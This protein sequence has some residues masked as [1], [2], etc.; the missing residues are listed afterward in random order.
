MTVNQGT[1]A[2]A[3]PDQDKKL[4][5]IIAEQEAIFV[6]RQP[7]SARLARTAQG[8]LAGG[9]T[10]SWQ[11]TAPQPVWLSH[12]QGSKVYDVDGQAY[13]DLHGG[14]GA[15]LAG[16]AHPA[17][18]RAVQEQVARGTHFAQ[19]T[20]N[21]I[22]VAEEL[23]RRFGLPQWR[24]G[25]SGTEA[26]MDAV[27]LM[28]SITGRDL[29]IKVEGGYHGHH[30]SVQ[31][32]VMPEPEDMG[33]AQRPASAAASSGIPDAIVQLT[34]VTAFND[35]AGVD[36]VL[37][38]H[39]GQVAG[40]IVE[41]IMMNAGIIQ[42][43]PG[44]LAALKDLLHAHGALLTFDEVKTGLTSGPA[45][46][47]GLSGVTPDIICLAKALGGGVAVAAVGGSAEVMDH[48]ASG[49][50]EIVGTFNGNPLAM[51][52]ARAMLT[53]VATPAAYDHIDRLR[54]RAVTGIEAAIADHGLAA[55]VVAVGAKGCVVFSPE[56][57]HDYRG[58]L[59][60]DDRYSHAHWLYQHNGGVFLPPWG[61]IEQWLISVQHDDADI[62]LLVGNFRRFAAAVTS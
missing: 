49:G 58:F 32:S 23:T 2:P 50:Y 13:V 34:R 26:T 25:N 35:L 30:D 9:V 29:I 18:V 48:V 15:S 54:N 4:A 44:Y 42:P 31:V 61:K 62:D 7:G 57:V 28:R 6:R 3:T 36:R 43:Q 40:M 17:I 39:R 53:E 1:D 56:P 21:A 41:P 37:T 5:D 19:P 14:Y 24:F 60:T 46:V 10:S 45:G 33:P 55:H 38:E 47:T 59:A 27:H 16:H 20:E 52:A 8:A 11:I 22:A 51:A 12:G